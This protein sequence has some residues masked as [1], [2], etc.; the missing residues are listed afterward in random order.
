MKSSLQ[1]NLYPH[2]YFSKVVDK[3][4]WVVNSGPEIELIGVLEGSVDETSRDT[5]R[6][7]AQGREVASRRTRL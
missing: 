5:W 2:R 4:L 3:V 7:S 1:L 6:P